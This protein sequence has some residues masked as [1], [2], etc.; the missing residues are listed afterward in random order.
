[1]TSLLH[2]N[3]SHSRDFLFIFLIKILIIIGTF[4]KNTLISEYLNA[5]I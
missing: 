4:I 5:F 2:L 1:M 3:F